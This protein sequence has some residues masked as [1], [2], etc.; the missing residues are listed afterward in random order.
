MG[1]PFDSFLLELRIFSGDAAKQ[2]FC[3]NITDLAKFRNLSPP[4]SPVLLHVLDDHLFLLERFE[5]FRPVMFARP[6]WRSLHSG[7]FNITSG[8]VSFVLF[9]SSLCLICP[10]YAEAFCHSH[11]VRSGDFLRGGNGHPYP[12][13]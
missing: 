11:R 13:L 4:Y 8:H 1:P 6:R 7:S 10:V 12:S 9:M 5:T 2:M 3:L